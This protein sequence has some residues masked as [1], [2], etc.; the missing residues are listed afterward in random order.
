MDF[1]VQILYP[2]SLFSSLICSNSGFLFGGI[3][4][5]FYIQDYVICEE[6]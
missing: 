5:V 1:C 3:F 6:R 2:E 4:R